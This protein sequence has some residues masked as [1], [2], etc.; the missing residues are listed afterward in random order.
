[1]NLFIYFINGYSIVSFIGAV[2]SLVVAIGA[3]ALIKYHT[4][5]KIW[6]DLQAQYSSTISMWDDDDGANSAGP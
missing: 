5:K 2:A 4:Q 1:M 3:F 6:D